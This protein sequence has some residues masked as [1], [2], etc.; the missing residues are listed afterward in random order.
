MMELRMTSA[1]E[2]SYKFSMLLPFNTGNPSENAA[3]GGASTAD[4]FGWMYAEAA[5]SVT[6]TA[7]ADADQSGLSLCQSQTSVC[8]SAAD[9]A[10]QLRTFNSTPA[11]TPSLVLK[12]EARDTDGFP[13][14]R[15]GEDIT[16][17]LY[18]DLTI[19]SEIGGAIGNTTAVFNPESLLYEAV[20]YGLTWAS[21]QYSVS[22][23]TPT[24]SLSKFA[25]FA[26][27]CAPGYAVEAGGL[28]GECV[29]VPAQLV[30]ATAVLSSAQPQ[31]RISDTLTVDNLGSATVV[32]LMP[33]QLASFG[34]TGG[35]TVVQFDRSGRFVL[36]VTNKD[37]SKCDIVQL[38]VVDAESAG[39]TTL[40][41]GMPRTNGP[42]PVQSANCPR[43][44]SLTEFWYDPTGRMCLKRPKMSLTAVSNVLEITVDKL[45]MSQTAVARLEVRLVTGDL[46]NGAVVRWVASSQSVEP[47]KFPKQWLIL[48]PSSGTVTSSNP[49]VSMAASMSAVGLNDTAFSGP[50]RSEIYIVS[51]AEAV[52]APPGNLFADGTD[53]LHI[54]VEMNVEACAFLRL[55]DVK[56]T[57]K[58]QLLDLLPGFTNTLYPEDRLVVTVNAFD[59]EGFAIERP[60]QIIMLSLFTVTGGRV[61]PDVTYGVKMNYQEHNLFMGEVPTEWILPGDYRLFVQSM[62]QNVTIANI[63]YDVTMSPTSSLDKKIPITIGVL[64]SVRL[65]STVGHTAC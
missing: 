28:T 19:Q 21:Q 3:V 8:Y 50:L 53:H 39:S 44:A 57:A 43:G 15:H 29:P 65:I 10:A 58:P 20:F 9:L 2:G 40:P 62:A 54:S 16:V 25:R 22:I 11:G 49:V 17:E 12:V 23:T 55:E 7:S 45:P 37:G 32:D 24:G 18:L 64:L 41:S 56:V 60:T 1:A 33:A 26:V 27:S 36:R 35:S 14:S 30:C 47:G 51:R 46:P 48:S 6:V 61:A 38:E 63:S 34:V 31:F 4:G 13:L 5:G 42:Q 52:G 59:H